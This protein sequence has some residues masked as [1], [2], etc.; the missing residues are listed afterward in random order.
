MGSAS[1]VLFKTA[2]RPMSE[3]DF[4]CSTSPVVP[5]TVVSKALTL[6]SRSLSIRF[7]LVRLEGECN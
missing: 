3:Q 4:L 2:S 6:K 1:H 5:L 7:T